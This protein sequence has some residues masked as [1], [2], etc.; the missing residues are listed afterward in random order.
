MF[1]AYIATWKIKRK[2]S[3]MLLINNQV[4]LIYMKS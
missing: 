3:K 1:I 2:L 4:A